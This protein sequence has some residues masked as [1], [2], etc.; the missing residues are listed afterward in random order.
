LARQQYRRRLRELE[1]ELSEARQ[2]ADVGREEVIRSQM[3]TLGEQLAA[4]VGLGGRARQRGGAAER[5]RQSVTKAI[6]NAIQ[7]IKAAHPSLG[8]HLSSYVRTGTACV[9]APDARHPVVWRVH[10]SA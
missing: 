1:E 3:D 6:R 4:A 10:R 7:R 9:F 2:R 8:Q 5:A